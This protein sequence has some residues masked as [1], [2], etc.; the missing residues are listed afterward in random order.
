MGINNIK[1]RLLLKIITVIVA[2]VFIFNEIAY[3]A[4]FCPRQDRAD[5]LL[6]TCRFKPIS[7]DCDDQIDPAIKDL[8]PD[9]S[10]LTGLLKEDAALA[11]VNYLI[12]FFLDNSGP[13]IGEKG[14]RDLIEKHIGYLNLKQFDFQNLAKEG[15]T[16]CIPYVFPN[17]GKTKILR[18]YIEGDEGGYPSKQ[19]AIATGVK[20]IKVVCEDLNGGGKNRRTEPGESEKPKKRNVLLNDKGIIL[21]NGG[22]G[23][24]DIKQEISLHEA[25]LTESLLQKAV[26]RVKKLIPFIKQDLDV[27]FLSQESEQSEYVPLGIFKLQGCLKKAGFTSDL[28]FYGKRPQ[29]IIEKV[30]K[31]KPKYIAFSVTSEGIAK[32]MVLAKKLR[33][34]SAGTKIIFGGRGISILYNRKNKIEKFLKKPPFIDALFVGD[35]EES[36]IKFMQAENRGEKYVNIEGLIIKNPDGSISYSRPAQLE[37]LDKYASNFYPAHSG[38]TDASIETSRNC[39]GHCSYCATPIIYPNSKWSS[40]TVDSVIREMKHILCFKEP[41]LDVFSIIDDNF[42]A[43]GK[44]SDTRALHLCERMK[45]EKFSVLQRLMRAW[46]VLLIQN[47]YLYTKEKLTM[48]LRA[49]FVKKAFIKLNV[50]EQIS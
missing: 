36:L 32:A 6:P 26:R 2:G 35:G 43:K 39:Y 11:Y 45:K 29:E 10:I 12:A 19:G 8:T 21:P 14:M 9:N 3:T 20:G 5:T 1:Y 16:F 13:E 27:L 48:A 44:T 15:N 22:A 23:E 40:R 34:V 46:N 18:Y 47:E 42:S 37:N 38:R 31:R 49:L 30:K 25:H 33:Q 24:K 41:L 4:Q 17:Q 28:I 7:I 50:S